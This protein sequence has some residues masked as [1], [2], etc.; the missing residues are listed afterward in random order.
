MACLGARVLLPLVCDEATLKLPPPLALQLE[1]IL[2]R[3]SETA[4]AVGASEA[5]SGN[6]VS[7]WLFMVVYARNGEIVSVEDRCK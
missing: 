3:R 4:R 7:V 6:R 2:T 5:G 1:R